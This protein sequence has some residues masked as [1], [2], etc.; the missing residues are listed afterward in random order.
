MRTM[1]ESDLSEVGDPRAE[2]ELNLDPTQSEALKKV[3][4]SLFD[5]IVE[6]IPQLKTISDIEKG[7]IDVDDLKHSLINTMTSYIKQ[8]V[9]DAGF[10][11]KEVT[12]EASAGAGGAVAGHLA[13][14]AME[15]ENYENS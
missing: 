11:K 6:Y 10:M 8:I 14:S 12:Q 15:I 5:N 13:A 4:V 7:D 3:I 1:S 2:E 9:G